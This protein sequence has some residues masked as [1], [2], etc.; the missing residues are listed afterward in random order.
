MP[1]KHAA[2]VRIPVF[3]GLCIVFLLSSPFIRAQDRRTFNFAVMGCAHMGV[4][5]PKDYMLAVT[6][7]KEQKPDFAVFLGGM[8]D[9]PRGG[10][11]DTV[12]KEFDSITAR[13]GVPV[14]DV[15]GSCS[16]GPLLVEKSRMER[17]GKCFL[18]RY[19]KRYYSFEH[20]NSLFVFLDS[21]APNPSGNAEDG[22]LSVAQLGFLKKTLRESAK[23]DNIFIFLHNSKWMRENVSQWGAGFGFAVMNKIRYVFAAKEHFFATEHADGVTY[24]VTGSPPCALRRSSHPVLFHFMSVSVNGK[25][26]SVN[27][28]PLKS[29]PLENMLSGKERKGGKSGKG[30]KAEQNYQ[31]NEAVLMDAIERKTMLPAGPIMKAMNIR[32]GIQIADV[33]AGVGVFAFPLA[34]T[35]NGTGMVFATETDPKMIQ[36]LRREIDRKGYKNVLPVSVSAE[37]VDPFYKGRVFDIMLFAE[38]YHYLW[39]P[40][41][42]FRQL[43]PSL[44]KE[45]GRIFIL[46]FKNVPDFN[47]IEFD[48][49]TGTIKTLQLGEGSPAFAQLE[50]GAG[51]FIRNWRGENA[52]PEIREKIVRNFNSL[53]NDPGFF[54]SMLDLPRRPEDSDSPERGK[55]LL[56]MLF[57]RNIE[58]ARWLITELESEG[59]FEKKAEQLTEKEKKNVRRLNRILLSGAFKM[60]KLGFIQGIYPLYAE[61]A[62]IISEMEAAGYQFVHEHDFLNYHYFLEFK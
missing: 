48:D 32:P 31:L 1:A 38:L 20:K 56:R 34:E 36:A 52:P 6:K 12:W 40:V 59:V 41:D 24:I 19:K 7:I 28:V 17:M 33:G 8:V 11:V 15:P 47:E 22:R 45:T 25:D 44:T 43:R 62:R 49:F 57:P 61:K 27:L 9:V 46:H 53:L 55:A 21:D 39:R 18:D 30:R 4:C 13:L 26:I 51:D 10:D 5:E 50:A 60:D 14:Y 2:H 29:I 3:T 58:L 35:L 54:N 42:Y 37:G 16:W 23:F